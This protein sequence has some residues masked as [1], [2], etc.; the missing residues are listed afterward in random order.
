MRFHERH[1][2]FWSEVRAYPVLRLRVRRVAELRVL[3]ERIR[4]EVVAQVGELGET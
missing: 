4:R 2:S 3:R 1:W